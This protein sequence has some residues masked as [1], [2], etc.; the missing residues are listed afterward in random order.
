M[1]YGFR[2]AIK[3]KIFT[4][5][6]HLLVEKF[7]LNNSQEEHPMAYKD[8]HIYKDADS[9]SEIQHIQRYA[10]K[11]GLLKTD[12]EVTGA[13]IKGV[14][15]EYDTTLIWKSL[16]AGTLPDLNNEKVS[17]DIAV[18]KRMADKMELSVG[19]KVTMYFIQD[20]PRARRLTVSGIYNTGLEE[21]DDIIALGDI[22]MVQKLNNWGDSLVGGLEIYV[23][24][25]EQLDHTAESLFE[26]VDMHLY[27]EKVTDRYAHFF[28]WFKMLHQNVILFLV[29][30]TFVA[31]FNIVSIMLILIMERT[32]MIGSLKAMGSNNRLVQ[33]IFI[34]NGIRMT[35]KGLLIG[36]LVAIGLGFLQQYFHLIPLEAETY[37]I[38]Y[39]PVYFDWMTVLVLNLMLFALISLSLFIPTSIVSGVEPIKSIKFN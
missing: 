12:S 32:R 8:L 7:S 27:L 6:A 19:D 20:P 13:L 21:F 1:Y 28:D 34:F 3:E 35:L 25:F 22:R 23:D 11:W 9:I 36:N 30:I 38:S 33:R 14:G 5:S 29:I 37:Y 17:R 4:H 18:S 39:V 16:V 10:H 2:D 26:E 31:V 15:S 24:D